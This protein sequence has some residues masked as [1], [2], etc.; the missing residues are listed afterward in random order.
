VIASANKHNEAEDILRRLGS[1]TNLEDGHIQ[2]FR[3]DRLWMMERLR[4]ISVEFQRLKIDRLK[5]FD[6]SS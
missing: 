4:Q 5:G 3:L 2:Q 1:T 6:G